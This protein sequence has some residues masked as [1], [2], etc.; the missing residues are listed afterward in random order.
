MFCFC[1]LCLD[2]NTSR[3][4]ILVKWARR[5]KRTLSIM[6]M[7]SE[8]TSNKHVGKKAKKKMTVKIPAKKTR[9]FFLLIY[10]GFFLLEINE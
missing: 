3:E 4:D 9:D 5:K 2:L 7:K 6:T 1:L 8:S 10:L